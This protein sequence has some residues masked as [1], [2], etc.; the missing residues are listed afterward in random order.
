MRRMYEKRK[1]LSL[2]M[3][4][5]MVFS[6]TSCGRGGKVVDM[7]T[8]DTGEKT[9]VSQNSDTAKK[10]ADTNK[11]GMKTISKDDFSQLKSRN[12][13]EGRYPNIYVS[14]KVA[15]VVGDKANYVRQ[16]GLDE[17]V[18][19][20]FILSTLKL[21][22]AKKADLLAVLKDMLPDVLTEQQK[23]RKLSNLLQKMKKNG[24]IDVRGIAIN[25]E[26]Y[27]STKD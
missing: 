21:G 5:C 8:N 4:F 27:L 16:K 11:A 23:S 2:L 24:T 3:T 26:W 12:L 14:Y 15:K 6:L 18:C 22:P 1:I 17:E 25:S 20:Q 9:E 19:M 13:V 7:V 10:A